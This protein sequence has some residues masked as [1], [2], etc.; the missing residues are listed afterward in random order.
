MKIL[1]LLTACLLVAADARPTKE[2]RFLKDTL[3]GVLDQL[4]VQLHALGNTFTDTFKQVGQAAAQSGSDLLSQT[5]QQATQLAAAGAT[6]LL[7]NLQHNTD[8]DPSKRFL[9]DDV[10]HILA[11]LKLQLHALGGTFNETFKQVGQ[12]AAQQGTD[13]LHQAL[14]QGTNL[15]VKGAFNLLTN[16]AHPN[17]TTASKRFLKDTFQGVL[18]K[19]QE[20]LNALG[21]TFTETFKQVGQAAAQ[22][23]TDL[24]NQALQQ[25]AQLAA[26]GATNLLT[27][28]QHP[29]GTRKRFLKDT[30][31]GVL[32]QLK[33]Q[34][35]ALGETFGE[36]FKQVGQA[37]AQQGTDLLNQALQQGTQLAANGATG[38]LTN[39]QQAAAKDGTRKRFLKDTFQGV[40]DKLKEQLNALGQTFGET[41]KQ[42]GQSAAQSGT[43]LLNQALQQG[44]QL[45]A[46]GATNLLTNLQNPDGTRKRFLKDTFQG[47][48]DKLNE[49][50]KA[51]GNTFTETFKQVGQAAAQQGTDLVNQ[52]LQQGAQLAA[53]GA[54]SLLTNLQ[55]PDGTRKRFLKDTFQGVLSKLQEQLNALG[56]TFSETFKQVGQAAAQSGTDLLNQALQQGAQ[57]AANGATGLLTNLQHPDGTRKRFLKDTFKGVLDKLQEQLN[58][59]GQTFSETFKQ[60]GQAAAQQGTDLLNQALQQGAQV[61]ANG[62][63]DLLT[64]LQK[65]DG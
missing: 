29:D 44:A 51:L 39:L 61:A 62:A 25:G 21:Q 13:L 33:L 17:R 40:L 64:N 48:L 18:G 41:F 28:L 24:L 60:V 54:T 32:D 8:Q 4:K 58:A 20:Q 19:L 10:Q 15:A 12:A 55:H 47:V 27:N 22:Q 56:Q 43:D 34:L 26:N 37:A 36:T 9:K 3:Q 2:E 23:G 50:L 7:T 63:T 53:N 11:Q 45:A 6:N 52:A 16:L 14:Q 42:V 46:N 57:L 35:H 59:L 49:Q 65:T 31:Q 38:L 30:F 5:L 1:V